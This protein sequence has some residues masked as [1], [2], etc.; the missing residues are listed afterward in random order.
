MKNANDILD[1]SELKTSLQNI[2]T[3]TKSNLR[4]FYLQRH[5]D[6]TPQTFRRLLYALEKQRVII[7]IGAGLYMFQDHP[8][9]LDK[10]KFA[11]VPSSK[12]VEIDSIVQK[13]FRYIDYLIWDTRLLH[14][15]TTHQPGQGRVILEVEKDACESVFNCLVAQFPGKVFLDPDR[16]AFERYILN[17]PESIIVSPLITQSPRIISSGVP[18]PKLEKILVDIFADEDLFF[19]FHGHELSL[20]YEN[21]FSA[22]L[23][24]EKTLFRYAGRRKTAEKLRTFINTQTQVKLIQSPLREAIV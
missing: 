7:S 4:S 20:I 6:W 22:Y 23:V 17:T 14:E 9:S 13:S 16:T 8:Y 5:P 3:I 19:V 21:V 11:P 12:I 1:F 24:N 10:V 15:F 2:S 18:M